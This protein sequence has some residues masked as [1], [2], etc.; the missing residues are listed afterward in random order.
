MVGPRGLTDLHVVGSD[1]SNPVN[2]TKGVGDNTDA[3]WSPAK[4]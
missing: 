1:G 4:R 2:L 3:A